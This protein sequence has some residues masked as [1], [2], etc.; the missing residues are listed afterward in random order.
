MR[1][2]VETNRY[3][4]KCLTIEEVTAYSGI[5]VKKLR[6]LTK[7]KKRPFVVSLGTQI[8]IVRE[9]LEDYTNLKDHFNSVQTDVDVEEVFDNFISTASTYYKSE[10]RI[11]ITFFYCV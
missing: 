5:G 11:Y 4:K 8:Y 10:K 9:K 7:V 3:G 1:R 2:R 6:E